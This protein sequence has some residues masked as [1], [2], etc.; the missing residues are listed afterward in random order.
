[1]RRLKRIGVFNHELESLK[2]GLPR[3]GN[4]SGWCDGRIYEY[5]RNL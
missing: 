1:M 2:D 5:T 4:L 3:S